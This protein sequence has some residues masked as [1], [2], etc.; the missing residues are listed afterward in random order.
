MA[1]ASYLTISNGT[2]GQSLSWTVNSEST[3]YTHTL[4]AK[5]LD[6]KNSTT[7]LNKGSAKSGTWTPPL[8][9][10]TSNTSGKSFQ[11]ELTLTTFDGSGKKIG[12]KYKTI[13]LTIPDSLVPTVSVSVSDATGY[14]TT[15]GKYIKNKSKAKVVITASGVHGSTI[16]SYRTTFNGRAYTASTFT[17]NTINASGTL[18]VAVTVVDTRGLKATTNVSISVA[19]YEI[20]SI[21]ALKVT[22]CADASGNGTSGNF[23]KVTFSS[24]V[25]SLNNKNTA[26][27]VLKYK[28]TTEYNYQST[29]LTDYAN[30]YSVSG[31][32]FVFAAASDSSYNVTLTIT[33]GLSSGSK[34]A[35]G[36][37]ATKF[38]SIFGKGLGL[39]LGKIAELSG[40]FDIAFKTRHLGGLLHPFLEANTN[41]ND[42]FIPNTYISR[43]VGSSGYLNCPV[44]TG[45]FSLLVEEAGNE[46]QIRQKIT[47]CSKIASRT[48]ERYYYQSAWGAWL[49][50]SDMSGKVL[51]SGAYYMQAS[52]VIN[53]S[54]PISK[55]PS[56]VVF[57]W[58][59]YNTASGSPVDSDFHYF[60]VPKYHVANFDGKSVI[61]SDYYAE[62]KKTLYVSDNQ[63]SGYTTNGSEGTDTLTGLHYNNKRLVLR[64]VIG[65]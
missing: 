56:G 27:Y 63:I 18:S 23:L 60:F 2:L 7:I 41:L 31:G 21:S 43:A 35:T 53:L 22:R 50:T 38:F 29:T 47:T 54:E 17:S 65:V 25:F 9:W 32:V 33:D 57:V 1:T 14:F 44:T 39:A 13:L 15:Y 24:T 64:A 12:T 11:I 4:T 10:A 19:D 58:G 52:H 48:Y 61:F 55:Q 40:V 62:V 5:S 42:V 59:W 26:S 36:A 46:G 16:K 6:G 28:K 34:T 37:S 20:P 45:T 3:A 51:W 8:S 30:Q 49:C